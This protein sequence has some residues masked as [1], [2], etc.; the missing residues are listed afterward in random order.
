M[1][2][3]YEINSGTFKLIDNE[4]GTILM[5]GVMDNCNPKE[6]KRKEVE[7][8]M[9]KFDIDKH[10]DKFINNKLVVNCPTQKLANEFHDYCN[11]QNIT[12]FG[13]TI[14]DNYWRN[15]NTCYRYQNSLTF[16]DIEHY[17]NDNYLVVEFEGF[18]IAEEFN[19]EK[20][21]SKFENGEL[22][23]NCKSEESAKEFLSYCES[24]DYRWSCNKPTEVNYWNKN[25]ENTFYGECHGK[26][27][28]YNNLSENN[29][30]S[31][32]KVVEFKEI[33]NDKGISNV[34]TITTKEIMEVIYH[35]A[36]TIV[37]IKANH[38]YYKGVSSCHYTDTYDKELGFMVAYERARENQQK[39]SVTQEILQGKRDIDCV[40]CKHN[41]D[42]SGE[43]CYDRW[44]KMGGNLN[45]YICYE[46]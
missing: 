15:E 32:F 21:W 30:A 41:K 9:E 10:W 38:K 8:I 13:N 26:Y 44:F 17:E 27:L 46:K 2:P 43:S 29:Y 34:P 39:Y 4:T 33:T 28:W 24:K 25:K 42:N 36:E 37:L 45:K 16:A 31:K 5:K 19:I 23:V 40:T 22:I 1:P 35:G 20:H 6:L 11:T 3:K 18:N 12:W 7:R 14:K